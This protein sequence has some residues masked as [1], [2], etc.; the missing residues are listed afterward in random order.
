MRQ[1]VS[2]AAS[3]AF[4]PSLPIARESILSG[5]TTDAVFFSSSQVHRQHLCGGQGV[6]YVHRA[7]RESHGT[8]STFSPPS[9][10]TI[11]WMRWPFMP[12]HEPTGS[13]FACARGHSH[14]GAHTGLAGDAFY[15]YAACE[16][17]RHFKLEQA[18][19]EGPVRPGYD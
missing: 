3:R 12:T 5:T 15:F 1:P 17:L 11:F 14:F 18:A 4:C 10:S 13:T 7:Y 8:T 6:S 16:Y 9:S 19:Q 2:L